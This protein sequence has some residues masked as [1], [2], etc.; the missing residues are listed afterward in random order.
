MVDGTKQAYYCK[1]CDR[2]FYV[3]KNV[4]VVKCSRCGGTDVRKTTPRA[5]FCKDCEL[6][7]YVFG[8]LVKCEYC[9]GVNTKPTVPI[10]NL[11]IHGSSQGRQVGDLTKEAIRA[12]KVE[13]G[14][15]SERQDSD[16]FQKTT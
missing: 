6:G 3:P 15:A 8:D 16:W 1:S 12:G 5:F 4:D 10:P 14:K 2:G 7:F 11:S 9:G 13:V